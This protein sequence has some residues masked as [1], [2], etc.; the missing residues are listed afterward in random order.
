MPT[1]YTTTVAVTGY[2]GANFGSQL[3]N[4]EIITGSTSPYELPQPPSARASFLGLPV[5][6]GVT[7]T[8]D[9]WLGKKVTFTI[10]PQGA[11]GT[12]TWAGIVQ[13]YSVNPVQTSSADQIVEL[14]LLG[15]TSRLSTVYLQNDYIIP[16]APQWSS[17][18]SYLNGELA[19][20]TW[21]EVPKGLT[22]DGVSPTLTW[23]NYSSNISGLTFAN[24]TLTAGSPSAG[25]NYMPIGSDILSAL[26]TIW[27][28]KKNGWF[29]FDD[30]TITL[31]GQTSYTD[32]SAITSLDATDCIL[33]SSL[34]ANQSFG[35]IIN[36]A[37]VTDNQ[38][39]N[40]ISYLDGT[41][42]NAYGYRYQDFGYSWEG[43]SSSRMDVITNKVNAYKQP[44][45][46]LQSFKLD[47][48]G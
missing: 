5:V 24:G 12:V 26:T 43:G 36:S 25:N 10:A 14:D 34:Q 18:A 20:T 38:G 8:P 40:E 32:Y 19:K 45:D 6:S 17:F 33:W 37:S 44:N 22:W 16:G 31:N 35:N 28:T 42:Y 41:S 30:T 48:A 29:W 7:Q 9:W 3:D 47:S 11:T 21:D 27:S 2:A 15:Q 4:L 13:S 1:S 39:N 46:Y 23:N